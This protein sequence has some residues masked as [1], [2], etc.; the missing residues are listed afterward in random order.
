[1]PGRRP[2]GQ[3]LLAIESRSKDPCRSSRKGPNYGMLGTLAVLAA[4]GGIFVYLARVIG[5]ESG[6][7]MDTSELVGDVLAEMGEAELLIEP[8]IVDRP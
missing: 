8:R 1:M 3:W 7:P 4:F 5:R 6:V 2:V